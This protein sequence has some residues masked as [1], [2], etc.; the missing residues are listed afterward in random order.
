MEIKNHLPELPYFDKKKLDL[1]E[2]HVTQ[3][4]IA[5]Q[6]DFRK[7]V[8]G[9][10]FSLSVKNPLK[11]INFLNYYQSAKNRIIKE[12]HVIC[13]K[14]NANVAEFKNV[15]YD[16]LELVSLKE[17]KTL[18]EF[19]E[20]EQ[21]KEKLHS[22]AFFVENEL[23][24]AQGTDAYRS[25]LENE[26]SLHELQAN[27]IHSS[28][29]IIDAKNQSLKVELEQARNN[30]LKSKSFEN[31]V[32]A[33]S[34]FQNQ[35][36]NSE[37]IKITQQSVSKKSE[38][39][40]EFSVSYDIKPFAKTAKNKEVE[41]PRAQ[42][43]PYPIVIKDTTIIEHNDLHYPDYLKGE[44][45]LSDAMT[46][47]GD[48]YAQTHYP[49]ECPEVQIKLGKGN[50]SKN[51]L[52][53]PH[54][55]TNL[56][57]GASFWKCVFYFISFL[58]G[59]LSE[60]IVFQTILSNVFH[61]SG[62]K[63]V[64]IAFIPLVI[65]KVLGFSL[66]QIVKS[67]IAKRNTLNWKTVRSSRFFYVLIIA[68]LIYTSTLGFIYFSEIEHKRKVEQYS[69]LRID[70]QNKKSELEINPTVVSQ[71]DKDKLNENKEKLAKLQTEAFEQNGFITFLKGLLISL[72]SG[73]LLLTNAIL[74]NVSLLYFKSYNLK[75]KLSKLSRSLI[76]LENNFN[77]RVDQI[78]TLRHKGYY[79]VSLIGQRL[80]IRSL[81]TGGSPIGSHFLE[82][83]K[84]QSIPLPLNTK[85]VHQ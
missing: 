26:M 45:D 40:S 19:K 78:A 18:Q 8:T 2:K 41:R 20:R 17:D 29:K 14:V 79:I 43:L 73:L 66:Y 16:Y 31:G 44:Q 59:M 70:V 15:R 37:N 49:K 62:F 63:S 9:K 75:R 30:E 13:S 48:S 65:A 32:M 81:K 51:E 23:E 84:I 34:E 83:E 42:F 39:V 12:L 10:K 27:H 67:F 55:Q 64:C 6:N 46:L 7:I 35:K 68:L 69:E 33:W 61:L 21:Y 53:L 80:F 58:A 72:S 54:T 71:N 47:Y 38:L 24:F 85:K 52:H 1:L 28:E 57:S 5:E 11:E 82:K 76:T 22:N 3:T 56:L 74:L 36:H 50:Y 4:L 77:Y 60:M 25:I